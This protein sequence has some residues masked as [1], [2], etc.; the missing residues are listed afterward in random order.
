LIIS[1]AQ[2]FFHRFYLRESF[3]QYPLNVNLNGNFYIFLFTFLKEMTLTMVFLAAKVEE[4]PRKLRDVLLKGFTIRFKSSEIFDENSP[5]YSRL[6]DRVLQLEKSALAVLCFDLTIDHPFRHLAR[7]FNSYTNSKMIFI[8]FFDIVFLEFDADFT[9]EFWTI[10]TDTF[11][12]PLPIL[13]PSRILAISLLIFEMNKRPE[14]FPD[15]PINL[16]EF[17]GEKGDKW[18]M[19]LSKFPKGEVDKAL[20][21]LNRKDLL[22]KLKK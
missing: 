22:F 5:E 8:V 19:N 10:L 17:I 21:F 1:T 9:K 7:L 18:E 2:V 11:C 12:T 20:E 15:R 3:K 16:P 13:F 4:S 6:Y 14:L